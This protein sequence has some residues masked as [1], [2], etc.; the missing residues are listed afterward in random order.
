M[1]PAQAVALG[2]L[3]PIPLNLF[4]LAETGIRRSGVRLELL[5]AAGLTALPVGVYIVKL[6]RP[7]AVEVLIGSVTLV[8]VWMIGSGREIFKGRSALSD[9]WIGAL[10]GVASGSTGM[11]GPL[12][13]IA[14]LRRSLDKSGY[15]SALLLFLLVLNVW[16]FLMLAFMTSVHW[17]LVQPLAVGI[18][19]LAIGLEIGRRGFQRVEMRGLRRLVLALAAAGGSIGLLHGVLGFL[20]H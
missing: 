17:S 4:I 13:G 10:C 20:R 6:A 11:G 7:G 19:A 1:P 15:R 8:L 18:P 16:T 3:L 5:L 9:V 14:L 12:L 2:V